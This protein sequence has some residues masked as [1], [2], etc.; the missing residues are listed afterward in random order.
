MPDITPD[1][2]AK[3]KVG[4]AIRFINRDLV[5]DT[6]LPNELNDHNQAAVEYFLT[7]QE[8]ADERLESCK[9][10]RPCPL[11]FSCWLTRTQLRTRGATLAVPPNWMSLRGRSSSLKRATPSMFYLSAATRCSLSSRDRGTR[12]LCASDANKVCVSLPL[13]P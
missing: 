5:V 1:E 3:A 12:A 9:L 13:G 8:K 6:L 11:T 10:Q 4:F 2:M 7:I